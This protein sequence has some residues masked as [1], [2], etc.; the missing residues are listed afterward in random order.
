MRME[1]LHAMTRFFKNAQVKGKVSLAWR[2]SLRTNSRTLGSDSNLSYNS[3]QPP[4]TGL[5]GNYWYK[6]CCKKQSV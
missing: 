4:Q 5:D 6:T 2:E 1:P 3:S